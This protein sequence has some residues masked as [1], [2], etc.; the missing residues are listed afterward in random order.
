MIIEI[1]VKNCFAFKNQVVFSMKA[2]MR[3]KKFGANV[4]HADHFH[5]LKTA[6]LYGPN[7]SGKTCIVRCIHAI[8]GTLLNRNVKPVRHLF[9][10][11]PVCSLG[12]TFLYR[13]RKFSF[14]FAY[15]V[16]EEAYV[17][18]RFSELSKDQY[19]N[20]KEEVW[21][22]RDSAK[23]QYC[24]KDQ[25]ILPFMSAM[26]G[27]NLMIYLVNVAR[28][29]TLRQIKEILR[30]FASKIDI[31]DMNNIPLSHTIEILKN[32]NG[33]QDKVVEFIKNADLYL[34]D[35]AY[36][37]EDK[38][39]IERRDLEAGPTEQ[40]L[41]IPERIMDQIRLVSTYKGRKVPSMVFDSTGTKKITALA[42]YV[43]QGLEEGR[44]L[45]VDELDN[46]IHFQLTRAIVSMYN[47][48][49]NNGA[50]MIFTLHDISLMDCKRLFRKEQIW[51][52]HKDEEQVYVYS[53][54]EFTAQ[55]GV[56]DTSDIREKYRRGVF[57]AL[58]NPEL[59]DTLL[60]LKGN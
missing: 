56:R 45:V 22:E 8:K 3:N 5:V 36:I 17:Y 60:A 32:K 18:E 2:D 13:G 40:A 58:P 11:D 21:L 38:I 27:N 23:A 46:G 42:G 44:I 50:Q 24:C 52:V 34:E 16:N 57:G 43:V 15:D 39:Q 53:L 20:E 33:L 25:D 59:I 30:G 31:I 54:A 28:F 47:N 35:F 12:V 9:S 4:H 29:S 7:N 19:G 49:L 1:R 48:E 55:D 26:A 37:A 41:Q 10:E 14:D 6:G 51:F